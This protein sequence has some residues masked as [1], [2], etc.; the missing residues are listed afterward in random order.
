[1]R[2]KMLAMIYPGGSSGKNSELCSIGASF[3]SR[4][5][6]YISDWRFPLFASVS[7]TCALN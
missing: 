7:S 2:D 6:S 4:V 3:E 5:S 1:L